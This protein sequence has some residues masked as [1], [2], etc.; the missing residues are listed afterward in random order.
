MRKLFANDEY[1]VYRGDDCKWRVYCYGEEVGYEHGSLIGSLG[2][3]QSL[4]FIDNRGRLRH[5]VAEPIDLG[6]EAASEI[7]EDFMGVVRGE[8]PT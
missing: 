2:G 7:I 4:A 3:F 5:S 1:V 6:N 8:G